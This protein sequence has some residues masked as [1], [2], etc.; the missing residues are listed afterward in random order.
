M[1]PVLNFFHSMATLRVSEAE[2]ALLT[3]TA[4]LCSGQP[5]AVI[6]SCSDSDVSDDIW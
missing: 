2:Y 1:G 6:C 5:G 3:A 4:L